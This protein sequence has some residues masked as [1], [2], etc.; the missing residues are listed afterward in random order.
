MATETIDTIAVMTDVVVSSIHHIQHIPEQPTNVSSQAVAMENAAEA[1]TIAAEIVA[2]TDL[3]VA[4]HAMI[5]VLQQA[6]LRLHVAELAAITVDLMMT[7]IDF[8]AANSEY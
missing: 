1:T 7:G 4:T 3:H 8:L 6:T 2:T 5:A